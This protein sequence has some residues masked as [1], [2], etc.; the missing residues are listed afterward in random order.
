[1]ETAA[2]SFTG[3]A[4]G[5]YRVF[6]T[7]TGASANSTKARYS[8]FDGT[9]T[10]RSAVFVDQERAPVNGPR[11]G[12][13]VFQQ[14]AG[15][16]DIRSGALRVSLNN[17]VDTEADGAN[18]I[19]DAI[20]IER[21]A[22]TVNPGGGGSPKQLSIIGGTLDVGSTYRADFQEVAPEVNTNDPSIHGIADLHTLGVSGPYYGF[23]LEE[24][25]HVPHGAKRI[26]CSRCLVSAGRACGAAGW[27]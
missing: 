18:V 22:G 17:L 3:L 7:W 4:S 5:V 13:V 14:L 10:L 11:D 25:S 9:T 16:V 6:A 2:W 23:S 27:R 12:G 19:A 24:I 15:A 1:M 26:A 21:L 8:I 20:R